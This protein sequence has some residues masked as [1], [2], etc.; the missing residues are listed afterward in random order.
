MSTFWI[1]L[2]SGFG[3]SL[4]TLWIKT[5]I[6]HRARSRTERRTFYVEL[7]TLLWSRRTYMQTAVFDPEA[8]MPDVP[9]ERI[10]AL[11]ALLSIDA[12]D[13]VIKQ[14][15]LCFELL[16]RFGVSRSLSVPVEVDEHGLYRHRF[17]QVRNLD[18][19]GR[20]LI[21]RVSLGRIADDF[22]AAVD[23]LAVQVRREIHG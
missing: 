12:T 3:G 19:E 13:T 7:L 22:G 9:N 4:V 23:A 11:N 15:K 17:D 14:A 16:N 6:D 2:G 20:D 1:V 18:G 8:T 5:A 10:D 21:L